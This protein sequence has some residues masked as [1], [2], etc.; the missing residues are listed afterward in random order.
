MTGS[1]A[2]LN[3][4]GSEEKGWDEGWDGEWVVGRGL[5]AVLMSR[6]C[7]CLFWLRYKRGVFSGEG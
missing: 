3:G 5:S 4:H 2:V 7:F 6:G 1:T